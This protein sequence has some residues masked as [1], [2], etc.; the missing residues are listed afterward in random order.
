MDIKE[1]IIKNPKT[2]LLG[3]PKVLYNSLDKISDI[4]KVIKKEYIY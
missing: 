1:I 2:I 3:N 4:I